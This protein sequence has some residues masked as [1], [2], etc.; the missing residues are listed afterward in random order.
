[1]AGS[2]EV[3]GGGSTTILDLDPWETLAGIA[4]GAEAGT[5]K[6]DFIALWAPNVGKVLVM[7]GPSQ[8]GISLE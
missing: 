4:R 7:F 2:P 6:Q 8:H 3:K 5:G 1:L